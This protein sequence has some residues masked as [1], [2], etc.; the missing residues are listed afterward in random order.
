[1]VSGLFPIFWDNAGT[2]RKKIM[3]KMISHESVMFLAQSRSWESYYRKNFPSVSCLVAP[4]SVDRRVFDLAH[5]PELVLP[6][7]T[8]AYVGWIVSDKGI[9]YLFEALKLLRENIPN[10]A[11][12]LYG[13]IFGED[14]Y[15]MSQVESLGLSRNV[16]FVGTMQKEQLFEELVN[17]TIFVFPSLYEGLPVALMEAAGLGLPCVSTDVG[18][19]PEI[20]DQGRAGLLV[21]PRS[22]VQLHHAIAKLIGSYELR[23]EFSRAS[24]AH[25]S[26]TY[27]Y[28]NFQKQFSAIL[29]PSKGSGQ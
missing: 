4:A 18:G 2:I 13:P 26:K 25:I 7:P 17:S 14:S 23:V 16:E 10:I 9:R 5:V 21:E 3:L 12:R 20:L 19:C 24:R 6:N 1:M 15:W 28:D 8:I 29:L 11:L 27:N 22:A